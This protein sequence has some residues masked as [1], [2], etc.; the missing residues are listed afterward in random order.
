[1]A[2]AALH[3]SFSI[4]CLAQGAEHGA[5]VYDE[6]VIHHEIDS[7]PAQNMRDSMF[8]PISVPRRACCGR[9]QTLSRRWWPGIAT[10]RLEKSDL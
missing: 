3:E 8:P 1:M 10:P 2:I 9:R 5:E 4:L 7:R 6:D